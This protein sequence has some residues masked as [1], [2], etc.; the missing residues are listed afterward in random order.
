MHEHADDRTV[1]L[2]GTER[3]LD[4]LLAVRI[5]PFLGCFCHG[6]FLRFVPE[7]TNVYSM[8]FMSMGSAER[9]RAHTHITRTSHDSY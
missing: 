1:L 4:V 5:G 6:L 3:F 2:H 7:R 8:S 9:T